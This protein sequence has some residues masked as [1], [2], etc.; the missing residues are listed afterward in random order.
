MIFTAE[1]FK[2]F[3]AGHS[4]HF[5][6]TMPTMPHEYVTRERCNPQAFEAAVLFIR[7]KGRPV[8]FKG[9][10]YQCLDVDGFRYWTMGNPLPETTVLNRA[11]V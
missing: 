11:K 6:K 4:W 3:I 7:D 10:S 9:R 8:I 5:A 2:E 1:S